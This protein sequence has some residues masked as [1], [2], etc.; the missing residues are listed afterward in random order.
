MT[1]E[2]EFFTDAEKLVFKK[3]IM[4]LISTDCTNLLIVL[5]KNKNQY[6]IEFW[7]ED[8]THVEYRCDF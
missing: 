5:D 3:F 1:E 7:F 8:N 6:V 2:Y 4:E